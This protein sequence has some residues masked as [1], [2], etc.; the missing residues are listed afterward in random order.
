MHCAPE[1]PTWSL[2]VALA[3]IEGNVAETTAIVVPATAEAHASIHP[4]L[5][6]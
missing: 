5:D 1:D 2:A 4:V 3:H 6:E